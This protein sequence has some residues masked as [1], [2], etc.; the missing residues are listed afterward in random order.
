MADS[1]NHASDSGNHRNGVVSST[2]KNALKLHLQ[3]LG[4][5]LT[6]PLCLGFFNRPTLLPCNHIFCSGCV[7][8][9]NNFGAECP[10][11]NIQVPG[12][13]L[14]QAPFMESI[15]AIY[16]NMKAT[17]CINSSQPIS[18][19][20]ITASG[21]RQVSHNASF[22][23]K[24]TKQSF[25][26]CQEGKSESAQIIVSSRS[27]KRV[28]VPCSQKYSV[29]DGIEKDDKGD[30]CSMPIDGN[31][32]GVEL[33][34]GL[35]SNVGVDHISP[36]P[37]SLMRSVA[38]NECTTAERDVNP[39]VQSLLDSPPSF[40]DLR[41]SD[42][43]NS[44]DQHS[45]QISDSSLI[46]GSI[47]KI[48]DRT[49]Q[50]RPDGSASDTDGH[51]RELKRPKKLDCGSVSGTNSEQKLELGTRLIVSYANNT[52]CAFCQSSTISEATGQMLHYS[53]G[54]LVEGDGAIVSDV[55]H[56][57]KICIDWAPQV[58]FKDD[59][60]KNLKAEVTRGA[61]LKCAK[62]GVKGA[63]L[64][65]YVKSC[66]RSYHVTC[67]IEVSKCRW[68]NENFLLLCPT[69]CSHRFPNEKLNHHKHKKF[70][71]S[72]VRAAS[73]GVN[74]WVF[75]PSGLSSEEKFFL[76]TF[77]ET[78]GA[79][80]S[81]S[82]TPDVTH[83]IAALDGDG[84]YVRTFKI[85]MAILA[86]KWIVKI[87]WVKA[88]ME[89]KQHVDEEPYEVTLDNYGC[90]SGA[91]GGRLRALSNDLKLFNGLNFYFAG[92]FVLERMEDYK[93]LVL[94][95]GGTVFNSKEELLEASNHE[96]GASRILVVY[97]L[98][99]PPGCKLGEE[100]TILW[101]RSNEAQDI[102]SKIGAEYVFHT[103]L[104]ESIARYELQPIVC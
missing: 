79:T 23:G 9:R 98:D 47:R 61:K 44:F 68:D 60:I 26:N 93:K 80:L 75:C 76:I 90:R 33:R 17:C 22:A 32:E 10:L 37:S 6:C 94:A 57:H 29:T 83:V 100:V 40:G 27:N 46:R 82:W 4:L 24:T 56:V 49:E 87:D 20:G 97:N 99:P 66:R 19:D 103:W 81:K 21:Q 102:A 88:C 58:Y 3:K 39:I 59:T 69:H 5:E 89:A 36:S 25:D 54:K 14:R 38:L 72:N 34:T 45:E 15:V 2:N 62:C 48:D 64:G 77:A 16:K 86:G 65:C 7:P 12:E 13:D 31:L 1:V 104:L 78:N 95:A 51:L 42:N 28:W 73:N 43:D 11:C 18:S 96:K 92:E 52:I 35:K 8:N 41:G 91:K 53:K 85:F 63:A 70:Q 55:M 67:A 50:L 101:Q 71:L 74:N 84:A 30:T